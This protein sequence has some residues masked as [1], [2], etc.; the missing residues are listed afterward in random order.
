MARE[1]R[2]RIV[3]VGDDGEADAAA[4][5]RSQGYPIEAAAS[6]DEALARAEADPG[7]GGFL[8]GRGPGVGRRDR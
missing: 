5:L 7:I 6:L 8:L 2:G 4:S 3:S 1:R